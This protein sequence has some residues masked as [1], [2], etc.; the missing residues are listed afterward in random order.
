MF[1]LGNTKFLLEAWYFC[2]LVLW[3]II[4]KCPT[5]IPQHQSITMISRQLLQLLALGLIFIILPAGSWYYLNEGYN[6]RKALLEELDQDLGTIPTFELR[7]QEGKNISQAITEGKVSIL[8]FLSLAN[9][10]KEQPLI[11]QLYRVQDQFDK[12][13]DIV[14]LTFTEAPSDETLA[15]YFQDL[16]VKRNKN[17]WHFLR[18]TTTE[19]EQIS[20]DIVIPKDNPLAVA[21]ADTEGIIR[22][23]YDFK[24]PQA[25][26][27]LIEHIANLMPM[28]TGKRE[29]RQE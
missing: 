26:K 8:N 6:Y 23:T 28:D 10:E 20:N 17:Q 18:G 14:F 9:E 19:L 24:D 25:I 11:Q 5:K 22:Y 2:F 4:K 27:K 3:R 12:R 29:L 13:D 15:T 7:N 21:I 1:V 16:Q